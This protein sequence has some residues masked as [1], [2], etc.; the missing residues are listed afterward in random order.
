MKLIADSARLRELFTTEQV[1]DIEAVAID[2]D[3]IPGQQLMRRAAQATLTVLLARWPTAKRLV[4]LCGKGNNAGDGFVLATLATQQ[5]LLVDV[6]LCGEVNALNGDAAQA[7]GELLAAGVTPELFAPFRAR[8][9]DHDVA[10]DAMLGTG[11]RGAPAGVFVDAITWLNVAQ[12]PCI[13]IDVPSGLNADTGVAAG[14]CVH[15]DVTV[16]FIGLKRGLMTG[17]ARNF[18]GDIHVDRLGIPDSTFAAESHRG[19]A[20]SWPETRALLPHLKPASFKHQR[21]HCL[22]IGG[23]SGMGGAV[24]LAAEACLRAGAGVVSALLHPQHLVALNVRC[25]EVM[26]QGFSDAAA[27]HAAIARATAIV[28]GPGLSQAD[29]A[30]AAVKAALDSKKPIVL[31]A[32]ALRIVAAQAFDV[33]HAIL[34]PHP[35]EAAALLKCK[36]ADIEHDRYAAVQ[37]LSEQTAAT[38]ILKGAGSLIADSK[39]LVVL[40]GGNAGM[41]TAGSGDV[42]AG[43]AGALLA[44]GLRGFDAAQLAASWHAEAGDRAATHGQLGIIASDLI[45][46]IP[47]VANQL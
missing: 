30:I 42:L 27:L 41:A 13:A 28:I 25:P 39:R 34:T 5:G 36:T 24:C 2:V 7:Y 44:Q 12:K 1:R 32:D 33:A 37:H 14:A 46:Q 10:V 43:I 3:G 22:I 15:A 17:L 23:A 20:V 19:R 6:V 47:L 35:G 29:W 18:C 16:T 40:T 31:D 9:G 11:L 26:A 38:I 4:V 45:A 21:G 8:S